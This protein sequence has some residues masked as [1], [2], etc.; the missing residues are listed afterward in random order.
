MVDKKSKGQ[1]IADQEIE[2]EKQ[3]PDEVELEV[4]DEVADEVTDEVTDEVEL[5]DGEYILKKSH[6]HAG[7]TLRVGSKIKPKSDAQADFLI[8]RGII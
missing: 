4:T 8:G 7:K 6:T 1:I 3:T 2:Q 5:E